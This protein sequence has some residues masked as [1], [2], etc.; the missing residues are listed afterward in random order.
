M[1]LD[2]KGNVTYTVHWLLKL[3]KWWGVITWLSISLNHHHKHTNNQEA[4]K[5]SYLRTVTLGT[6]YYVYMHRVCVSAALLFPPLYHTRSVTLSHV[7]A[8]FS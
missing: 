3:S 7:M 2:H 6:G 1:T 8:F 5:F 4:N